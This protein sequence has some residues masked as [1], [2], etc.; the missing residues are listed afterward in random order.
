MGTTSSTPGAARKASSAAREPPE[1]TAATIARSDPRVT[2][3]VKPHSLTRSITCCSSASLA[4]AA[5]LITIEVP[6]SC[7]RVPV[8]IA[9]LLHGPL[10]D[11][12][13][14][15]DDAPEDPRQARR[16]QGPA[17]LRANPRQ[18]FPLAPRIVSRKADGHLDHSQLAGDL[19]PRIE[20]ADQLRVQPVNLTPS[21]L[22][23]PDLVPAPVALVH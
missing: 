9:F 19:R 5:M 1:P 15:Q 13:R 22:Q 7:P 23:H 20:Q 6:L 10:A 17:A 16:L 8:S 11:S 3:G 21:L 14:L 4:P 12:A 2:C 18:H